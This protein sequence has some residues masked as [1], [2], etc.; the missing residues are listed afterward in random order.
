MTW[1]SDLSPCNY[2]RTSEPDRLLAVGW[3]T[4]CEHFPKGPVAPDV[5]AKIE[6]L[7]QNAF[8]IFVFRGFHTCELCGPQVEQRLVDADG[9]RVPSSSHLNMFVPYE[10]K[11]FVAPQ[12]LPH[13]I[14]E[15]GY[16]PPSEFCDGVLR[17]PA[18]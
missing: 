5:L 4:S 13:Y 15:H 6:H 12:C 3:L 8:R 9:K 17:C 18:P 14:V 2:F 10:G 11:L 16:C 1:Y 7:A